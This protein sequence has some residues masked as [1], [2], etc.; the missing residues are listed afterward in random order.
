MEPSGNT[1]QARTSFLPD[2]ILW[3]Y[4]FDS[5]VKWQEEEEVF[6]MDV[7]RINQVVADG[8]PRVSAKEMSNSSSVPV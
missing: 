6:K 3:G 5:C 2:E 4:R 8:T 1:T 7:R